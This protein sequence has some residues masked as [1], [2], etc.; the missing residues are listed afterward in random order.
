MN[1]L[2]AF[3]R[4]VDRINY[5]VGKYFVAWILF[6]IMGIALFEVV[7]RRIIGSPH[8]WTQ[9]ILVYLF[10]AHFVL[11]LGYTLYYK[12]HVVVDVFTTMLPERAQVVLETIV[13]LV[14]IG[15]F[16]YVMIPT[17]FDFAARAWASGERAPTAFNSPVYPAKTLIP[18]SMILLGIQLAGI[19]GKNVLFLVRGKSIEDA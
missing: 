3:V 14:F 16:V 13:Y 5:Y 6:V 18:L 7:T 12:E 15:A 4:F 9:E 19:V 2:I 8:A 17:A 1:A 10:C 11:A